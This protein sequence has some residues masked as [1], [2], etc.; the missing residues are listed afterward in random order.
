MGGCRWGDG[1]SNQYG[2]IHFYSY[3]KD[4][5]DPATYPKPRF[6]SEFGYESLP[7]WFVY[8]N[9]TQ[10]EDWSRESSMTEFRS[11][12]MALHQ[13]E[14]D[15]ARAGHVVCAVLLLKLLLIQ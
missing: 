4:G 11:A 9:V 6:V 2:D 1:Q 10:Q 8:Q 14:K 15:P 13:L 7:S 12:T 5:F 3:D